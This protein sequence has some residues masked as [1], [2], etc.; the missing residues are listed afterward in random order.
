MIFLLRRNITNIAINVRPIVS[1]YSRIR[2]TNKIKNVSYRQ[3][4]TNE[5]L[6]QSKSFIDS[7]LNSIYKEHYEDGTLKNICSYVDSKKNG[8][9]KEIVFYIDGKKVK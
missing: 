9:L 2:I 6:K 4:H 8:E 1:V 5:L 3:Y 7:K